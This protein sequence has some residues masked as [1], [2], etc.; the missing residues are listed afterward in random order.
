MKKILALL[1]A[2]LMLLGTAAAEY[3]DAAPE[4]NRLTVG[5][6]TPMRGDFFTELWANATS[7]IDVR[8]LL[9]G[10]NLVRWDMKNGM[11][12]TDPSVVSGIVVMENDEGDRSYV[13]VLQDDLTYSDGSR[14]TAWDYAF[15]ILLEISPEIEAI[16][17]H[18]MRREQFVGYDSYIR[19]E[20]T[21]LEGV[22]VLS[23]DTLMITV[24]HEFLPCFYELGLV[25]C[26]PYPIRVIA[27]G[28]TVRDDGNGVYLTNEDEKIPEPVFTAELLKETIL[29]PETGYR[30]HPSVVSG[31]YTLTGWDGTTAEF[32]ANPFYKG[33]AAGEKPQIETL[34]YTAADNEDQLEK[35]AAGGFGLLNK[36]TRED[37]I[38][39]GVAALGEGEGISMSSYPRVGLSYLSFACERKT[40]ASRAVRQAVAWCLD[41]DRLTEEY[42]GGFGLRVDGYYGIGQ[43]MYGIITGSV[44]PP[45]EAPEEET[46]EAVREYEEVLEAYEALNLDGLTEYTA[47]PERAAALLDRDGWQINA[48]GVQEKEIDGETVTLE[49]KMIYPEGNSSYAFFEENFVPALAEAGIRLTMEAVP[50]DELLERWYTLDERDADLIYLA[51]NFDEI[52]DPAAR[53]YPDGTGGMRMI[54]TNADDAELYRIAVEMRHTEPGDVLGYMQRW[55]E[56]Q[57]RFNEELPMLPIYSNIYF[58]FYTEYLR[59]YNIASEPTWSRAIVGAY[60]SEEAP[61]EEEPA[62]EETGEFEDFDE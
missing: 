12:T 50:M 10:Y 19:G 29:N 8:E 13:F 59:N 16:G 53:F 18:A 24:R 5:N 43:W 9:H 46:A 40:M 26:K 47:D 39:K 17:A 27:P 44:A 34:I 42:T 28:V 60:L 37:V 4:L 49:L 2:L 1:T 21:A 32:A 38:R 41:R 58:D 20:S 51:S 56:F 45:V 61:E 48:D 15:S 7:D 30:S 3:A 33:N 6:P 57:E 11:Y 31:P 62:E 23:D 52:F 55:V 25:A 22:R 35:L 36:V 54:Y 14:I